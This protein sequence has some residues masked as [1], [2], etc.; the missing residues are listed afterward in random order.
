MGPRHRRFSRSA[1]R[2]FLPAVIAVCMLLTGGVMT[3]YLVQRV[4]PLCGSLDVIPSQW[5]IDQTVQALEQV[6]PV[7][8]RV[9]WCGEYS[10]VYEG[11]GSIGTDDLTSINDVLTAA[12]WERESASAPWTKSPVFSSEPMALWIE[13][14]KGRYRYAFEVWPRG[15]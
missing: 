5:V 1:T 12:G 10:D 14:G 3:V 11:S 7:T 2:R 15:R 6:G 9:Q 4:L 8:H 13:P